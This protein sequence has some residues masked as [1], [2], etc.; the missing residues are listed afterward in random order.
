M[1]HV[2]ITQEALWHLDWPFSFKQQHKYL[3]TLLLLYQ[4]QSM[5]ALRVVQG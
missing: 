3:K 1:K 4:Q 2:N 5:L